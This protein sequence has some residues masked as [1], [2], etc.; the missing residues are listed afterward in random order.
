MKKR[1]LFFACLLYAMTSGAQ[2]TDT[3]ILFIPCKAG[4]LIIDGVDKGNIDADDVRREKLAYGDHYI[5]LKT[6]AKKYNLTLNLGKPLIINMVK[7]GCEEAPQ[8]TATKILD[9]KLT[10]NGPISQTQE[11]N[12]F[13]MDVDDELIVNCHL[14]NPKG[15]ANIS[16]SRQET[17]AVIYRNDAF[18]AIEN[19]RIKIP[20]KGIYNVTMSTNAIFG[21][22]AQ[23]VLERVPSKSSDPN[24]KTT[25]G[26]VLDTTFVELQTTNSRVYSTGAIGHSN[27]TIISANLPV[28]TSYWAY[29]ISVDQ[30]SKEQMQKLA[31]TAT[32]A[33]K[34][35]TSNPLVMLGFG[36]LSA[37]PVLNTTAT[38]NYRFTDASNAQLFAAS[39]P[40][41]A[42]Q[43]K[44]ANNVS[45]DYALL[46]GTPTDVT[47]CFDNQS[48]AYG[49]DVE[50]RVV[51]FIINKRLA[52]E[53]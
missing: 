34:S 14:T 9:K 25:I 19:E 22:E 53:K 32:K 41:S 17:G 26:W 15:T 8:I 1:I 30:A 18:S 11:K 6:S 48:M 43:F 47:F 29:Y 28:N 42:Y 40:F 39:R 49:H 46:K 45:N 12:L 10:L 24:F 16:I 27:R 51:A 21:R 33:G 13:A 37:L 20:Q 23:I 52:I 38:V 36:L 4:T 44:F 3:I 7:L 35:M 31:N 2:S 50:V 5:Q